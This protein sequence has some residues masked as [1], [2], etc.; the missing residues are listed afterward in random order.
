MKSDLSLYHYAIF[1]SFVCSLMTFFVTGLTLGLGSGP[2]IVWQT[3]VSSWKQPHMNSFTSF[4]NW[5][6]TF[7]INDMMDSLDLGHGRGIWRCFSS[8]EFL[9]TRT[10]Q[11]QFV[12]IHYIRF[13]FCWEIILLR[14]SSNE[15]ERLGGYE[16]ESETLFE[17]RGDIVVI[18]SEKIQ[19]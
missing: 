6:K 2:F 3:L 16:F 17:H 7:V 14:L 5:R 13:D 4:I 18:I 15:G 11:C 1:T 9:K 10:L 19:Q 12:S 8:C